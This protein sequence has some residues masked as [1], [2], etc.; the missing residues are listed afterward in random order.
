MNEQ[1]N[2]SSAQDKSGE[3]PHTR[4]VERS[5]E[6]SQQ[7]SELVETERKNGAALKFPLKK[8]EVNSVIRSFM[9]MTRF[10]LMFLHEFQSAATCN[11]REVS[12]FQSFSA[13]ADGC[14]P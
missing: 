2:E 4:A 14:H 3:G 8:R 5:E 9:L 1:A 13:G 11:Y 6:S 12:G 10:M 7:I